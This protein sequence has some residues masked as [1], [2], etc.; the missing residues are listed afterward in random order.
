MP[1]NIYDTMKTFFFIFMI[2]LFVIAGVVGAVSVLVGFGEVTGKAFM[3][4]GVL[5]IYSL[6]GLATSRILKTKTPLS[7]L[8][9]IGLV[10]STIAM[11]LILLVIWRVIDPNQTIGK[12]VLSASIGA[13]AIAH[14]SLLSGKMKSIYTKISYFTTLFFITATAFLLIYW[15][16]SIDTEP[17]V[18]FF[19]V[20]GFSAVLDVTGTIVTV[21]LRKF[22]EKKNK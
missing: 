13:F 15:V 6:F 8:S 4:M 1:K 9:I 14:M 18:G 12:V 5:F 22:V 21:M 16:L 10:L 19:N 17:F 20:L 11:I 3:T 2:S 7:F